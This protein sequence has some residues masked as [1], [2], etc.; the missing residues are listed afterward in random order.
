MNCAAFPDTLLEAE[1]FGHER[2]AFTGAAAR[3]SGR[4]AAAHG[5]TLLLDEVGDMSPAL[6]VKLLRVLEEHAVERLGT[7]ASMRRRRSGDLGDAPQPRADGRGGP[8]PGGSL[9]SLER[10]QPG[11]AAAARAG[12]RSAAARP[13]LSEQIPS[14]RQRSRRGCRRPPG[15]PCR[16]SAFPA[17]FASSDTRS[18]TPSSW[19]ETARSSR[20]TFRR[21]SPRGPGCGMV[22]SRRQRS[23]DAFTATKL[24][25]AVAHPTAFLRIEGGA[26]SF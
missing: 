7:N 26:T 3:R 18:S 10:P 16:P 5:G 8:V 11:R 19:R 12:G 17:T 21:R 22:E 15:A 20:V 6:Q 25:E 14:P 2:G 24:G 23:R 13:V 1:L 4:F 9:P